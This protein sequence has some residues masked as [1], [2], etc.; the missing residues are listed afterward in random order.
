MN[1]PVD[2]RMKGI[3]RCLFS[4]SALGL[5]L[6]MTGS[7]PAFA[8]ATENG[9]IDSAGPHP[10]LAPIT[11]GAPWFATTTV[12]PAFFWNPPDGPF[13]YVSAVGTA[14]YVTDDFLKGDQFEVFDNGVSLGVTNPVAVDAASPEVGPDAAFADPTYSSGCFNLP[15]GAHSITLDVIVNP[16]AGGRG[17]IQVLE[18]RCPTELTKEIV[19]GND[20]D[21]DGEID[22]VVEVGIEDASMY[23]FK[24]TWSDPYGGDPVVILDTVPAEWDVMAFGGETQN[25]DFEGLADTGFSGAYVVL[26]MAKG[27]QSVTLYRSTGAA[28]DIQNLS[29]IA[30][31]S[32]GSS[33]LNP[34]FSLPA[35]DFWILDLAIPVESLCLD[36]ADVGPSDDDTPVDLLAFDG[37]GATGSL[38]DLDSDS[39]LGT[40]GFPFFKT[41]CVSAS[42]AGN[43]QSVAFTSAGPFTNSLYWDN[44]AMSFDSLNCEI[45]SANKKNNDK[46]ATKITCYPD[47]DSGEATF[48]N[49]ARCHGNRNNQK[50]RPTSCGGL[51]LNDGAA[52]Y[53]LDE[54]GEPI[55]PPI[56]ESNSL[57]LAA[58]E[59]VNEDGEIDYTGAGDEDGDGL[60]DL[61]ESCLYGTDPCLEDT[62]GDGV[63]DGDEIASGCLDPLNPDTDGDGFSDGEDACPCLGDE[64]LGVDETGCPVRSCVLTGTGGTFNFFVKGDG[65]IVPPSAWPDPGSGA[66]WPA[67][68]S[69]VPPALE[70]TVTNTNADGCVGPWA[71]S[72]DT[73]ANCP[74]AQNCSGIFE[75]ICLGSVSGSGPFVAS[76]SEPCIP[77]NVDF[78]PVAPAAPLAPADDGSFGR[79]Q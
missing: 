64:G 71:D 50:C 73:V 34:F 31:P 40:D 12:P 24:I 22:N 6:A 30:D 44:M 17:Y 38:V 76:F 45:T 4:V 10:M 51:Y 2:L 8:D 26:P 67:T 41:N 65:T 78:T 60:T 32:W 42:G 55:Y 16:F 27:N 48:W 1:K 75:N 13:D 37:P 63:S 46:S 19:S 20:V 14:V 58:V 47:A 25:F 9:A 23:D 36:F 52:A 69:I 53:L 28:F 61:D 29:F 72:V 33:S 57:C 49:E 21:G 5:V 66:D 35:L 79:A 74:D 43:I 11:V 15:P 70:F 54:D 56:D 18:G 68:G 77:S 3:K 39:W 59:D 62:D 7:G